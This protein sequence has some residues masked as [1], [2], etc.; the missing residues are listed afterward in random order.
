VVFFEVPISHD[1]CATI[2]LVGLTLIRI[3]VL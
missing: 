2:R 3:T 1:T